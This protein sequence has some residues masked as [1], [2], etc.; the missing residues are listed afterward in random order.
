MPV[1]RGCY[2]GLFIE[3]KAGKN[4][5][6]QEQIQWVEALRRAGNYAIVCRGADEAIEVLQC[7]LSLEKWLPP[8]PFDDIQ[9]SEGKAVEMGFN[10]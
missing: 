2:H 4:K 3:M 9:P 7:Y 6:T 5:A 10:M 1:A 8:N